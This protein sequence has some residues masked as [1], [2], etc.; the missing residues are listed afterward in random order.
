MTQSGNSIAA[1]SISLPKYRYTGQQL[2]QQAGKQLKL[3]KECHTPGV[4]APVPDANT[5]VYAQ[6][7]LEEKCKNRHQVA[8][9]SALGPD[10]NIRFQLT[11]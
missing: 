5:D 2:V 11:P 10:T 3:I 6:G 8:S 9:S 7:L 4:Y 1:S